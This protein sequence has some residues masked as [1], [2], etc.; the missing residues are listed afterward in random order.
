MTPSL[1]PADELAALE[2]RVAELR[3]NLISDREARVGASHHAI[4]ERVNGEDRVAIE[5][6]PGLIAVLGRLCGPLVVL[7]TETT[8]LHPRSGD[9]LISLAVLPL[10]KDRGPKTERATFASYRLTVNPGRPSSPQ[11]LAVHG[12]TEEFLATKSAFTRPMASQVDRF[13][14]S[15]TI[16][17]HNAPF[18]V[19]FLQAECER[20]GM[21][22]CPDE[23]QVVD[24]RLV[25]KLIW[26]NESGSLDALASRLG[27]DRG[28][29]DAGHDAL[30]DAR[31]LARCLPGLAE[32]LAGRILQ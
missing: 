22:W 16:V 13:I 9:R 30:A 14:G 32:A 3:V 31:L 19:G 10:G 17:A 28:D 8:G 12:L 7:D 18:D 26:P 29:R 23:D 21:G 20:L 4:V 6:L 24:T 15:S 5:P 11:T 27:V 2:A 1:H 25:S